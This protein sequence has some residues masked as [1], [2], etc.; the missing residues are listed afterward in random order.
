LE[1]TRPKAVLDLGDLDLLRLNMS[2]AAQYWNIPVSIGRRDRQNI[3]RK[4]KQQEIEAL[5][6]ISL[7][8]Q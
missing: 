7:N 3:R 8:K 2:G 6:A 5:K 1:P 4:L